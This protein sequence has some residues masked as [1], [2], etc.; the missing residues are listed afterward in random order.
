MKKIRHFLLSYYV[1]NLAS[2]TGFHWRRPSSWHKGDVIYSN[3]LGLFLLYLIWRIASPTP[4]HVVEW[5][6]GVISAIL[7]CAF[8][9]LTPKLE[10]RRFNRL[11]VQDQEAWAIKASVPV[12]Y[13]QTRPRPIL[14]EYELDAYATR[15]K[16]KRDRDSLNRTTQKVARDKT[17]NRL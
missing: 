8:P 10:N 3:V 2:E 15:Q 12:L 9:L 13:P 11:S 5:V 6:L 16:A 4:L 17:I 14:R 7:W 1:L